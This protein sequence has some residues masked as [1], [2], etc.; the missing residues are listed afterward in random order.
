[1]EPL[2]ETLRSLCGDS[3][4]IILSQEKRE[5]EKQKQ[6]WKVFVEKFYEEFSVSKVPPSEQDDVYASPDI[7]L[8]RARKKPPS[9]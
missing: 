6:T 1:L 7:V 3:T 2:L 9:S 8:L 4:E 5:T